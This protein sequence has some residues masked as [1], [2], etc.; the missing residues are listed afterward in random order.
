MSSSNRTEPNRTE[1]NR[2]EPA[3]GIH[4]LPPHEHDDIF[5]TRDIGG[6]ERVALGPPGGV[7]ELRRGSGPGAPHSIPLPRRDAPRL[8]TFDLFPHGTT[9]IYLLLLLYRTYS[10]TGSCYWLH[11]PTKDIYIYWYEKYDER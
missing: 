11:I 1:P 8:F 10:L 3:V 6:R 2:T 4:G 5:A 7:R 9:L